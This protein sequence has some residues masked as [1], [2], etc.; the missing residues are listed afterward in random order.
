MYNLSLEIINDCNL[1]C[2]YC[3]LGD[4]KGMIMDYN[5]AKASIDMAVHEAKKQYDKSLHV[6]FIGGEPLLIFKQMKELVKYIK[7][8]CKHNNLKF[9]FSTTTNA[10]LIN[11]EIIDFFINQKFN[12]KVS[13][14]GDEEIH[15][16][17]R[18]D[19]FGKGT[20]QRVI[21][22]IPLI[23][24]YE[25]I[26]EKPVIAAQVITTNNVHKFSE[27]FWKIESLGFKIIES[28]INIYDEW[29]KKSLEILE[30]QLKILFNYYYKIKQNGNVLYWRF[31]ENLISDYYSEVPFYK[32]KAGLKSCYVNVEGDFYPCKDIKEMNIGS[33]SKGLNVGKIRKLISI[34]ETENT[35]CLFCHYI[36]HCEAKG[37]IMDNYIINQQIF[38]PVYV[39]CFITKVVYQLIKTDIDDDQK[40]AFIK[41]YR[42]G[43]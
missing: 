4:K 30:K 11:E 2:S 34:K 33:S 10:T 20:Y 16:L 40:K 14:D 17:N 31:L 19:C 3:Y 36:N 41:F 21:D 42:R 8:V 39:K 43:V 1:N 15:N 12:F 38:Q 25:N 24:K 29:D 32:C 22:K 27:S 7:K 23:E 5:I 18:K 6:Y 37:C 9:F 13:I 35:D 26:I 28:S